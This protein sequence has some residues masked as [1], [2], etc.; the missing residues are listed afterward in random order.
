MMQIKSKAFI[1]GAVL[2]VSMFFGIWY[3][4]LRP[5]DIDDT[6]MPVAT[7]QDMQDAAEAYALAMQE[8]ETQTTL[9]QM[10]QD[11]A[12]RYGIK[13]YQRKSDGAMVVT[14][15]SGKQVKV[16]TVPTATT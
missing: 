4:Y 14:D 5:G 11:F 9:D 6:K 2:G 12:S 1:L 13:I 15:T 3:F 16:I 8:G 10:N 7:D